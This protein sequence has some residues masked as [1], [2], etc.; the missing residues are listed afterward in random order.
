M[1]RA[2]LDV[3]FNRIEELVTEM[4]RFV[5]SG[6]VGVAQFRAD[7]AGLLVVSVAAS[8]ESCVKE[9]L[10]T[11]ASGHHAAFGNFTFNNYKRL[12]SR[13]R[14]NDLRRYARTFDDGVRSRFEILLD[15][16]KQKIDARI[17]K[18]IK[19]SY[20]QIL[21]WRNAFA[22]AGIR[23]TTIE[24]AISTHRLAKRVLYAFD[25]AFNGR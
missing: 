16:R 11:F 2:D 14:V 6:A 23:N 21:N 5:P 25:E 12:N 8:Y 22:H 7:L 4:Q 13:I 24:E 10:L 20:E 19:S 17:G 9:T 3:H 1:P 18:D 15:Q